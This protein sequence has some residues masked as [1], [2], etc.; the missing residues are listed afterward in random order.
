[1]RNVLTLGVR[2]ASLLFIVF[3]GGCSS[4]SIVDQYLFTESVASTKGAFLGGEHTYIAHLAVYNSHSSSV[5]EY[6]SW[7]N[8]Y[9]CKD[10][11]LSHASVI[12]TRVGGNWSH[13]LTS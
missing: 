3:S 6:N 5:I 8:L 11:H 7:Q 9:G 4:N 13:V 12:V 10:H 2:L 1:M